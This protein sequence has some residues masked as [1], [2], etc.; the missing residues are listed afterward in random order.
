MSGQMVA[1]LRVSS[2]EQHLDR[3]QASI[4]DALSGIEPERWFEDRCSGGS[5]DRPG[6]E[7]LLA[8][9]REDDTVVVASMDRLAR[10]T[11]DLHCLVDRL[12]ARDVTVRFLKESQDVHPGLIVKHEPLAP[13]RSW[14][15]G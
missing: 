3:Q 14:R 12:V 9:V 13:R 5:T 2:A 8:H 10:S 7:A 4:R 1:Y 11:V 15:C 6:L